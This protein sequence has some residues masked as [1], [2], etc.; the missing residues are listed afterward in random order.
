M[1]VSLRTKYHIHAAG[2]APQVDIINADSAII[3]NYCSFMSLNNFN[4]YSS[5]PRGTDNGNWGVLIQRGNE[6]LL[7]NFTIANHFWH[8]ISIGY[9]AINT[10]IA[11]GTG[12]TP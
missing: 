3:M 9:N 5:S 12:V 10:V 7:A 1:T 11:N 2:T 6:Q 4:L 8:D